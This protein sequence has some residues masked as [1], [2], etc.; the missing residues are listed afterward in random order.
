MI[1]AYHLIFSAYG[2]WLPNDPRG[3]WSDFVRSWELFLAAGRATKVDTRLSVAG[4]SHD[5]DARLRAKEVLCHPAVVFNGHQAL[6]I[7]HGFGRMI[8]NA[9][10]QVYASSILLQHVHMVIV[11]DRYTVETIIRLLKAEATTELTKDGRHPLVRWPQSDGSL[12]SPWARRR[13]KVFL[14]QDADIVS[15]IRYVEDNPVKE[16]KRPQ[17]WS[18]GVPFTPTDV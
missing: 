2:F 15:A 18:F 6:S 16:G 12:P 5:R 3:S 17:H 13:W 11:H 9:R 4:Q 10:Y 1:L 8:G 7:A 14:N